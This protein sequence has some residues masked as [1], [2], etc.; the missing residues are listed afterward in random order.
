MLRVCSW[1]TPSKSTLWKLYAN[2]MEINQ[3][4]EGVW[5]S[6]TRPAPRDLRA[7]AVLALPSEVQTLNGT[8]CLFQQRS[9]NTGKCSYLWANGRAGWVRHSTMEL[10]SEGSDL[11]AQVTARCR[12]HRWFS[13]CGLQISQALWTEKR[14]TKNNQEAACY[15]EA[16]SFE[17]NN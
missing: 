11:Q 15:W 1:A 17:K 10:V 9:L 6:V 13:A 7:G 4:W 14:F 8:C 12:V 3:F 5:D 16:L 2:F